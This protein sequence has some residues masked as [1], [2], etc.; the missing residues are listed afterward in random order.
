[1][2]TDDIE[3]INKK[4]KNRNKKYVVIKIIGLAI[5]ILSFVWA[6]GTIYF[7]DI[8]TIKDA[9][10]TIRYVNETMADNMLSIIACIAFCGIGIV[11]AIFGFLIIFNAGNLIYDYADKKQTENVES[12]TEVFK[13]MSNM[14]PVNEQL[15]STEDNINEKDGID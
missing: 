15:N 3:N 11:C 14:F 13:S 10:H 2:N 1:M 9:I 5:E 12:M 4:T 7:A 8:K 6:I